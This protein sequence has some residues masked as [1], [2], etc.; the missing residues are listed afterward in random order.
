MIDGCG[1]HLSLQ[2][3]G[4]LGRC[5]GVLAPF[6]FQLQMM[7]RDAAAGL[8][9]SHALID[10]SIHALHQLVR[11]K[12]AFGIDGASQLAIDDVSDALQNAAH[13]SFG[14]D[15]VAPWL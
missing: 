3:P 7:R 10:Q 9:V 6:N 14:Q 15:R 12:P 4:N 1:E 2:S 8:V 13:Q 11:R 5:L